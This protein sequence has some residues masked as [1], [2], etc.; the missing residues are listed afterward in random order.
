MKIHRRYCHAPLLHLVS[1][2]SRITIKNYNQTRD[3]GALAREKDFDTDIYLTMA[4]NTAINSSDSHR[5]TIAS[6]H[7]CKLDQEKLRDVKS[8]PTKLAQRHNRKDVK[9]IYQ[10]TFTARHHFKAY[11]A[12]KDHTKEQ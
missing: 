1:P 9:L 12:G 2:R 8:Q 10:L 11:L 6:K 3:L 5:E 7:N 4:I